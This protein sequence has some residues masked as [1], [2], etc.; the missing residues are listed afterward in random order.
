MGEDSVISLRTDRSIVSFDN[1]RVTAV[2]GVLTYLHSD[3]LGS[4]TAKS[5]SNGA[6]PLCQYRVGHFTLRI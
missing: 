6:Y 2:S 4:A 5:G 3:H 1:G